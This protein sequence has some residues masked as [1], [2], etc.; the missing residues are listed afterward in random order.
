VGVTIPELG[1]SVY[2]CCIYNDWSIAFLFATLARLTLGSTQPAVHWVSV[3][4]GYS[5]RDV[6]LV[7]PLHLVQK[8]KKA[9][10]IS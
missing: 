1:S 3:V 7:C 10:A 9:V 5:G 8:V 6:Y 4:L 2:I